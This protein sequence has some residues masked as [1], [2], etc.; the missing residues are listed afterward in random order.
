M[1]A[2]S[3]SRRSDSRRTIATSVARCG[4]LPARRKKGTS[5]Q[6]ALSI[7]ARSATNVSTFD[8]GATLS[9][10]RYPGASCPRPRPLRTDPD[11]LVLG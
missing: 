4:S 7:Q 10:S 5:F 3:N 8:S 2:S 9:S 6:R 11:E 1:P